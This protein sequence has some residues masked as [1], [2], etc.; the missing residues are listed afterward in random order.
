MLWM[1]RSWKVRDQDP[2]RLQVTL[3]EAGNGPSTLSSCE[4]TWLLSD[5]PGA[6]RTEQPNS[7]TSRLERKVSGSSEAPEVAVLE[8]DLA[9]CGFSL[10]PPRWIARGSRNVPQVLAGKSVFQM[11]LPKGRVDT[12]GND[13]FSWRSRLYD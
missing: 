5:V 12:P 1:T 8:R 13:Q 7:Q 2:E 6:L 10:Q 4:V 9:R 11:S 3:I